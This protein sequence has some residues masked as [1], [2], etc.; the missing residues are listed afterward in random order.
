MILIKKGSLC[1]FLFAN[2]IFFFTISLSAKTITQDKSLSD[3]LLYQY[4]RNQPN[5]ELEQIISD[6]GINIGP[7][8]PNW[9]GIY[10]HNKKFIVPVIFFQPPDNVNN[11][12]VNIY[13]CYTREL[14]NSFQVYPVW[15]NNLFYIYKT[16][17]SGLPDG[18][19]IIQAK[20]YIG[21]TSY[22]S[23][24][25][26]VAHQ[27]AELSKNIYI[28][29]PADVPSYQD[30]ISGETHLVLLTPVIHSL[31][32]RKRWN[33]IVNFMDWAH[34]SSK[35]M[36]F[37]IPWNLIEPLPGVYNFSE[38]DRILTFARRRGFK[39]SLWFDALDYPQWLSNEISHKNLLKDTLVNHYLI[40][41]VK[42][43]VIECASQSALQTY[44]FSCKNEQPIAKPRKKIKTKVGTLMESYISDFSVHFIEHLKQKNLRIENLNNFYKSL[45]E[46]VRSID[47]RRLI[48]I[49]GLFTPEMAIWLNNHG[50]M[51]GR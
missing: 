50:V 39:V 17:L 30:M 27:P 32:G 6:T 48:V 11:F 47:K 7:L 9:T 45:V 51:Q 37:N 2:I 15:Q 10:K 26:L 4:N 16:D 44:F 29:I 28:Q 13:T 20:E 34:H 5:K 46:T 3:T 49:Y 24:E 40:S 23:V 35:E 14:I 21:S 36:E 18:V 1:L 38:V 25:K 31:N 43:F 22:K 41:A 33:T 12:K 8:N 42:H 19:Y